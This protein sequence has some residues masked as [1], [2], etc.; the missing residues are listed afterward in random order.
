MTELK[1]STLAGSTGTT[2]TVPSQFSIAAHEQP[3]QA[4]YVRS[5]NR[6]VFSAVGNTWTPISELAI[7]L[8]PRC[9]NGFVI[10]TW[11][12]NF[13]IGENCIFNINENGQVVETGWT[14]LPTYH[15]ISTSVYDQDQATTLANICLRWIVPI[16]NSKTKIYAPTFR[17]SNTGA[18]QTLALNRTITSAGAD[19]QETTFSSGLAI[20]VPLL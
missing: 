11:M 19:G 20:E 14:N 5:D 18:A 6:R 8:S 13:E 3:S 12:L 10:L 4:V 15:G 2:I 9:D 16:N 7:E 17:L 1:V